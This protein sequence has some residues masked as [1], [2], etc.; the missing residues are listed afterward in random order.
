MAFTV[1]PRYVSPRPKPVDLVRVPTLPD[2]DEPAGE[3]SPKMVT[4]LRSDL[5]QLRSRLLQRVIA[6]LDPGL[7]SDSG[8]VRRQIEELFTTAL[9]GEEVPLPR[10]ERNRLLDAVV[11][12]ITSYGPID[13]LL[14]DDTITEVMVNGPDQVYIEREGKLYETDVKFDSDD[15]VKRIIDRIIAPLGRRCDESSP[16]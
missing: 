16:M 15:H 2:A 13:P 7:Q 4:T 12:D 9:E 14:H 3:V 10:G 5:R 6:E 1:S 11:A 8:R